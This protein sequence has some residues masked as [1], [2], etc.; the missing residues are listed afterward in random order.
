[1]VKQLFPKAKAEQ[2]SQSLRAEIRAAEER[3]QIS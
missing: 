1:M 2:Q 3:E